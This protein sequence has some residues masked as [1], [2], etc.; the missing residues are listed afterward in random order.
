[1][2][3]M[4]ATQLYLAWHVPLL[5]NEQSPMPKKTN[6]TAVPT[7]AA[8]AAARNSD[9]GP[10]Q[11]APAAA[12]KGDLP[13]KKMVDTQAL[14]AAMP[15]NPNK[16]AEYGE[17][18]AATPPV[19]A[20]AQPPS[21]LPGA[22]TLSEVNESAKV[23]TVAPEGVNA[24]IDTLDR[25]R[26]DSS[27]QVLTTNQG[28][29]IA[30]N[31]SSLKAGAR[32][33]ALL[34]DFILR[35]KI[36][37]FDH[38][39][40]PERIVHARGSGAHGFFECYEPLTQYTKA[41][42]FKEA[43]K[44]TPVFVRFS[45]VAGERGSKDTARDVRGFAVK[46]YTD[47]G[48]WDL[49][50][51]NM[52]VF[53]IQDAIKFPDLVHAVK[54]EPHHQMPQAASA[55]DTFWDFVS[56]MPESTHMLMWQMSDRAIPRSY[57]MMQGFGV[58]TFRLVNEAGES[59]L[60]KFH[61]QPKLGTHSMVWEEAV[62]ISG[63]DPDFHRRDL[64][65]AIEAGEYPEW[66]LG[67]QIFTEEQ[68]ESFSFDILDAT[69]LIP[70]E[71]VP[72]QVVGRMVLNRNPDNFFAETEQVAFCTAHIV[73]GL[74][75]TNDPLL[76]GR[77]HSY[78]DTQ[79]SRLGGP[80]FHELPI[81]APIAQVHNNQRDGMH[82]QAIHR[83]RVS[84]EP[85]SLAG[86]CPFQ[87]GAA[88]GFTSVARRIDAKESADKVRIKPEKFAD[89]YTQ[90]RLF[91][92]SQSE[93]EKAHIGNAFRFELSKVTVPAIRERV[94][95][96]LLNAAPDLAAR[97]AQDLGMTLPAP[98]PKALENPATPEVEQS[99]PLSLM[100]RP[101]DGGIR[102]RKVAILVA[103]GVEG[104]S[105][106][107]LVVE[108]MAQGAVPRLVGA[109]LGTCT[110]VGGE[111]LA[112][113][114]T[115]E[116]SPGFL[117]DALVLPDGAAAVETLDADAHTLEFVRDQYWHC[118]TILAFGASQALLEEARIPATMADGS[119]DPGL[120]LADAADADGAIASFIAA[121]GMPRHFGRE[122]DPPKA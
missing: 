46:F 71:L 94:V 98:L 122:N 42:P 1:M 36:T 52:P 48:N 14:A 93:A 101:G 61:W 115:M 83:G 57:R 32:G 33:P 104:E 47:E 97:L 55:H 84:Y 120:I 88:Q 75:F 68:A 103:D 25:V 37:H 113:D 34:E 11:P 8:R 27:G 53:F 67:L 69:K 26:V 59:V 70:E 79:I 82:R 23:G 6:N 78:V 28:V 9:S 99:P 4:R 58:H 54:P 116:N 95:A 31:Q 41:A 89:H 10:A 77:I 45:T 62:K 90:A 81:N 118:K 24:T 110:A 87:A 121:M 40:I 12:G 50:G 66:E 96:S 100:A 17:A 15:A 107:K 85:N 2:A 63:A 16:P 76:A 92:E 5:N 108:L 19:G 18:N 43:G 49:V 105:I 22:S 119:A 38:E 30:D 44:I 21:R 20:S 109:R 117:F 35:E 51:N 29:P 13:L 64:W 80:N 86:G 39:R 56:L 91:F 114:A 7:A 112:V 65:E 102:T 74:D 60:V 73:P 111:Q 72:I 106:G 3:Y